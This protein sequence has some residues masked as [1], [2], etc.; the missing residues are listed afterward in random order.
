V[1]VDWLR[2]AGRERS[3]GRS[4]EALLD[5]APVDP[6]A[7]DLFPAEL[8]RITASYVQSLS[9]ELKSVHERRFIDAEAQRSAAEALGMSRQNLRTLERKLVD[10]LRR[11]LKKAD[12]VKDLPSLQPKRRPSA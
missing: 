3:D 7:D 9:P 12:F 8:V 5:A 6:S 2:R 10:G 1:V 4:L 11:E